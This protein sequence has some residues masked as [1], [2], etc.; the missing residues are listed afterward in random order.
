[1]NIVLEYRN[2]NSEHCTVVVFLNG[3]NAGSLCLRQEEVGSF[4]QILSGGCVDG[5]DTFLS[6][7]H[8]LPQEDQI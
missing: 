4:Q 7:G 5:I 2:P 8:S 6:R 3:A 1:M